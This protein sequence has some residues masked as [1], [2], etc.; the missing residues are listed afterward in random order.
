MK[1]KVKLSALCAL[2]LSIGI[3]TFAAAG[4][5]QS[6]SQNPNQQ[7]TEPQQKPATFT[8]EIVKTQTG[9]YALVVDKEANRGYFLDNQDKAKQFEGKQVKVI[10][11]VEASTGTIHV[12]DIVPA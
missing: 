9:R 4:H 8:G 5:A 6:Q 2:A 7:Q 10:G 1:G 12:T 3:C 11:V